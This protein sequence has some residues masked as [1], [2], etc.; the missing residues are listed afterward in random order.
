[1]PLEILASLIPNTLGG[2]IALLIQIAI[3]W[4]VVI[5]ADQVMAHQIEPKRSLILA[6]LAYFVSPLVLAFSGI[7]VP[8]AGIIIPLAVWIILGEVLL[9]AWGFK[10]RM[11]VAGA[12]FVMYLLLN[13]M[14]IPG[15][16]AAAIGF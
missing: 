15:M 8:F 2:A 13:F 6:V 10:N 14:G 3:I 7:S 16:I 5:I 1:M 12:A 4:V 9:K 11:K